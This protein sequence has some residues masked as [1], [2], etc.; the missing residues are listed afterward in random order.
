MPDASAHQ[1]EGVLIDR[2]R[3]AARVRQL[4]DQLA[5]DLRTDPPAAALDAAAAVPAND[6][7]ALHDIVLMPVMTGAMVLAADLI[8]AL[9]LRLSVELVTVSSYAGPRMTSAGPT[10]ASSLPASLAGKRVVLIDDILDSGRTLARLHR[11][12]TELGV[13]RVR[14]LVLLQK[15][16]HREVDLRPEYV[17]FEIPDR[18]VVGYGL[19]YDGYYRNLPDICTLKPHTVPGGRA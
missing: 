17:G 9:P 16:V 6:P 15:L 1:I 14:T 18:F 8:R 4:A 12:L 7:W 2:Q 10:L 11:E 13:A 19:D 3:I 5:D